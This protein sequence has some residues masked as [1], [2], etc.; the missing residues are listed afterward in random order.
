VRRPKEWFH[1]CPAEDL[2]LEARVGTVLFVRFRFLPVVGLVGE[3]G[4]PSAAKHFC[5]RFFV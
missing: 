1:F 2:V 4:A 3:A 5:E